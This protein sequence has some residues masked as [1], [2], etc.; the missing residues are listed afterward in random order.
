M[1]LTRGA[2]W[3]RVWADSVHDVTPDVVVEVLVAGLHA[4]GVQATADVR[5]TDEGTWFV[6]LD[7][8]PDGIDFEVTVRSSTLRLHTAG[9]T[10]EHAT[11]GDALNYA[12]MAAG[13]IPARRRRRG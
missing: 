6:S 3:P 2:A 4:Y 8:E 12:A 1:E 13:V 11:L 5:R 9:G 10:V 7:A